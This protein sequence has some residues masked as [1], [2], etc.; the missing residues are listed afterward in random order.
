MRECAF[1]DL[2]DRHGN[3]SH[4][5]HMAALAGS[6]LVLAQG[7]GGLRLDG[8]LPSFR[9]QLPTAWTGY[10]FR[11]QWR[12]STIEL[13]VDAAGCTYRLLAGAPVD[14]LDHGRPL[15][16]GS[17]PVTMRRPASAAA[18]VAAG[19][20]PAKSASLRIVSRTAEARRAASSGRSNEM[21]WVAPGPSA[22]TSR[23]TGAP[24]S[25]RAATTRMPIR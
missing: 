19:L 4:G 14:I 11:L 2:E 23:R 9:P 6:W 5:L 21:V 8:A 13:A 24:T 22:K 12:G 10:R 20:R 1:V 15:S 7:W 16:V 3:T 18:S 25:P 17:D